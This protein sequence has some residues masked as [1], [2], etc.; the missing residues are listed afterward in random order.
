M[1]AVVPMAVRAA[2]AAA[3]II[4]RR[5][6][7]ILFFFIALCVFKMLINRVNCVSQLYTAKIRKTIE[8]C[9]FF[10]GNLLE[11]STFFCTFATLFASLVGAR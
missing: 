5:A 4:L 8:I 10:L 2:V 6:S 7:Q 3:M 1:H 9:N 11:L